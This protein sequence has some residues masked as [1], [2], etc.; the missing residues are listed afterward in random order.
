MKEKQKLGFGMV[1]GVII[2]SMTLITLFIICGLLICFGGPSEITTDMNKYSEIITKNAAMRTAFITFPE[3][4]PE[5]AVNV[6]FYF[7]YK[8]TW[9]SP[10]CEVFLQCSYDEADYQAEVERL[11]NT[12]KRY[13]SIQTSLR[14]DAEGRFAY[15][16]YIAVD[17]RSEAYE[18][19]LLSGENQIT[20]IYTSHKKQKDLHKIEPVYLPADFDSRQASTRDGEGYSI[21]LKREESADEK[22]GAQYDFTREDLSERLEFHPFAIGYNWFTVCT[23]WNENNQE[24]IRYCAYVYYAD[25]HD[26]IYGY[27]D[28][29]HYDELAGYRF[30]TVEMNEDETIA[31]VTYYDGDEEKKMEYEIPEI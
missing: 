17:S 6:D 11:E 10:S 16:V 13:G 24:I 3:E 26:S 20:Y 4:L 27:P 9:N 29:I 21:Y 28:E 12:R 31:I 25:E 14:T 23:Y 19:A 22:R 30:K 15:P 2:S 18:Y 8:D 7:S 1:V 5:S